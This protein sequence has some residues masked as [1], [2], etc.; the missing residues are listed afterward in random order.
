MGL[1]IA[2]KTDLPNTYEWPRVFGS[3][4][5][6]GIDAAEHI[7]VLWLDGSSDAHSENS[8]EARRQQY[9]MLDNLKRSYR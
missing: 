3:N 9:S 7:H 2:R 5:D 4:L 6:F 1:S 8:W